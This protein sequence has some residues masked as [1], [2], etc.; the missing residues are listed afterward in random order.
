M[1]I[2]YKGIGNFSNSNFNI[3]PGHLYC[4]EFNTESLDHPSLTNL[5][6]ANARV[7]QCQHIS[8]PA[9]YK[10]LT[11]LQLSGVFVCN[12]SLIYAC[13]STWPPGWSFVHL[14]SILDLL[15]IQTANYLIES[16]AYPNAKNKIEYHTLMCI[17]KYFFK[18]HQQAP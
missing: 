5:M 18:K 3:I 2:A 1:H 9:W 6:W 12:I 7:F 11:L 10:N 4:I 16:L 14:W 15:K 13:I 17:F 8:I